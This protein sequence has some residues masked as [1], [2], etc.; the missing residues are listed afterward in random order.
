MH[1]TQL[2]PIGEQLTK[3]EVKKAIDSLPAVQVRGREE[4]KKQLDYLKVQIDDIYDHITGLL[5]TGDPDAEF[6]VRP[7]KD[8]ALGLEEIHKDLTRLL[9]AAPEKTIEQVE[10]AQERL[11]RDIRITGDDAKRIIG[12]AAPEKGA[13]EK[14]E[15][16]K[17][18]ED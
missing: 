11:K 8:T 16:E 2:S 17:H 15:E 7:W 14:R 13:Q 12:K 3:D 10:Q 9:F 18:G 5:D 1:A 6:A 4:I